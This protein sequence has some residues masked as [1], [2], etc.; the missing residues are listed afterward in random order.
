MADVYTFDDVEY[1]KVTAI[2]GQ[3]ENQGIP[4]WKINCA[5]E[6]IK[7]KST[8]SEVIDRQLGE[9]YEYN[10]PPSTLE[11]AKTAWKNVSQEAL[12]VGSQVH[13]LI[14]KYIKYGKDALGKLDD[15]VTSAMIAFWDFEKEH[16]VKWI[17][18][19][20]PVFHPNYG[21]A[22]TLDAIAKVDG[23]ITVIDFK[24]SKAIYPTYWMQVMAYAKARQDM[25]LK[26]IK[27]EQLGTRSYLHH[28]VKKYQYQGIEGLVVA[29]YRHITI[30]NV[31]II[32]LDKETGLQEFKTKRMD[33]LENEF[34]AFLGLV[35]YYYYIAKRRLK[36]NKFGKN[37]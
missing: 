14:E 16:S 7:D 27:Y 29:S 30:E 19:E 3:L 31:G 26:H 24:T 8:L 18:S 28:D 35:Q 32:R 22:G 21:Y 15:K 33:S 17:E 10:I 2:L 12:D 25:T 11:E 23:K 20:R 34:T 4:I 13:S 6:Y 9:S 37:K 5:I 36:G 1:P